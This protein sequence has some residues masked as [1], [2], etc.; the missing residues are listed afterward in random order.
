[1]DKRLKT[2]CALVFFMLGMLT[3]SFLQAS[4]LRDI[5]L[6]VVSFAVGALVTFLI[7]DIITI[8]MTKQSTGL[9]VSLIV[10]F[11]WAVS[12]IAEMVIPGF[13]VSPF[14][15]GIMGVIAAFFFKDSGLVNGGK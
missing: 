3:A 10:T 8:K 2:L 11:M 13:S 12:I 5:V 1:M 4:L 9:G 6:S 7:R 15:H 14:V